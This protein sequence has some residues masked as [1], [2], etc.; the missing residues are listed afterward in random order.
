MKIKLADV[1]SLLPLRLGLLVGR[2]QCKAILIQIVPISSCDMGPTYIP[3]IL[4]YLGTSTYVSV[5]SSKF[6]AC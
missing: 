1:R 6:S 4:V 5:Y 3:S 2:F